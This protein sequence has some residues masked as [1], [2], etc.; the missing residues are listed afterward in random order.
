MVGV[1]GELEEC[2]TP[3]ISPIASAC[4]IYQLRAD[5]PDGPLMR[6]G[7]LCRSIDDWDPDGDGS[8]SVLQ[9]GH[10]GVFGVPKGA[11]FKGQ[12]VGH[13]N[14]FMARWR[15]NSYGFLD[16]ETG[17]LSQVVSGS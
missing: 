15:R 1:G 11:L 8:R 3:S 6:E 2:L 7:R 9:Y 16:P 4:I 17:M 10:P 5:C 14:I 13:A 12:P